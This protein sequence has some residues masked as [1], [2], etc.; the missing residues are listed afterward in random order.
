MYR[1]S[2]WR[3]ETQSEWVKESN[4]VEW[5]CRGW[6]WKVRVHGI[7]STEKWWFEE[8]MKHR[9]ILTKG[10]WSGEDRQVFCVTEE[11]QK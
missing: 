6:G 5:E 11:Y 7:F 10:W 4:E 2:F 1:V 8:D 3:K 9:M